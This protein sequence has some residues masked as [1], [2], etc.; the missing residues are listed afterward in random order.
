MSALCLKP[1]PEISDS[2]GAE[3]VQAI[4][5]N[6]LIKHFTSA[7]TSPQAKAPVVVLDA[8]DQLSDADNDAT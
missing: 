8:L 2:Y 4:N 5:F 3:Q 1:L 7:S 6:E